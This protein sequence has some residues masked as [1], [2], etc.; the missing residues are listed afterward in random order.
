MTSSTFEPQNDEWDQFAYFGIKPVR[1]KST[2]Y[3]GSVN[4]YWLVRE[5]DLERLP[6]YKFWK[7]SAMG[8][9]CFADEQKFW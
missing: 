7:E 3:E 1:Y 9:T 4:Y 6:F 8:S 5:V 2:G